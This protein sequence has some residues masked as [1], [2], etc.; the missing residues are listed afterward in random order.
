MKEVQFNQCFLCMAVILLFFSPLVWM[1]RSSVSPFN[2]LSCLHLE[3]RL[4]LWVCIV[5][6]TQLSI[7]VWYRHCYWNP[8]FSFFNLLSVWPFGK[9]PNEIFA[10]VL[11]AVWETSDR[12]LRKSGFAVILMGV[13]C[14]LLSALEDFRVSF[15]RFILENSHMLAKRF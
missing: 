2:C 1:L 13:K 8:M 4:A 15:V 11:S 5:L 14:S 6:M 3:F 12:A 7:L 9:I 10:S